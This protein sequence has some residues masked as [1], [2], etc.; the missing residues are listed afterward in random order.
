MIGIID[1]D[2]ANLY[3]DYHSAISIQLLAFSYWLSAIGYQLLAISYQLSAISLSAR[4]LKCYQLLAI[5]YQLSA[6]S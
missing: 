2:C 5:G 6:N 1:Q 3:F 4:Y